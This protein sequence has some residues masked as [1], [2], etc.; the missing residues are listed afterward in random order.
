MRTIEQKVSAAVLE[1]QTEITIKG[2]VFV[3]AQPTFATLIKVSELISL[4]PD[5]KP[6]SDDYISDSLMMAKDC[7]I[8]GE[9]IATMIIGVRKPKLRLFDKPL[10]EELTDFLLKEV[11][12][13][14]LKTTL[15]ELIKVMEIHDFFEVTTSLI[16]VNLLRKTRAV[17]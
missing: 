13:K 16:E 17:V 15:V 6:N 5:I 2:R 8:V 9:I 1:T 12:I 14:E 3:V 4:L 7:S 10:I 11:S